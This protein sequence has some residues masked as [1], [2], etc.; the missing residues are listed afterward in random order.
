MA[1][2]IRVIHPQAHLEEILESIGVLTWE[3][4]SEWGPPTFIIPKKSGQ[5]RFL[6]DFR[7]VNKRLKKTLAYS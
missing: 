4:A 3:G 6:T 7:E 2:L 5:V 1:G